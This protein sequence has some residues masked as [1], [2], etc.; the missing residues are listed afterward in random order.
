[1]GANILR[2]L[3]KIILIAALVVLF[4]ALPLTLLEK[5]FEFL[6]IVFRWLA[7]L[8]DFFGWGGILLGGKNI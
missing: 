5:I 3:L 8:I 1:M 2:I 4:G 7:Q 6:G